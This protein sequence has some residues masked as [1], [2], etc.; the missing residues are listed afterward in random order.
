VAVIAVSH[1]R[2]FLDRTAHR[3]FAF[4]DDGV[5]GEFMGNYSDYLE[6][7]RTEKVTHTLK[8]SVTEDSLETSTKVK[9]GK[10]KQEVKHPK[11]T[12][13]EK[14]EF[15]I[16]DA[17]VEVLEAKLTEIEEGIA[18]SGSD[19]TLLQQLTNQNEEVEMELLEKL[20]R[21]EYLHDKDK[22]SK[23]SS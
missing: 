7:T 18:S 2:Y 16:I 4:Q 9:Q 5:V 8:A 23:L 21:Q 22:L 6:A 15:D 10:V 20:E 1:D 12:F 19:Y 13:K 3:I 17:E 11:L 14:M